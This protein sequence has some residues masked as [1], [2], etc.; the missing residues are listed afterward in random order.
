MEQ[1][2]IH[3]SLIHD[4]EQDDY[5]QVVTVASEEFKYPCDKCD[6]KFR[7]PSS[8]LYHK[9][10][11]H[12]SG[13]RFV[14]SKCSKVFK[15]KQ[16]LQRHQ[17]VHTDD[18]PY[19]CDICQA[20]FKT[21]PNLMN[22]LA[23][24]SGVKKHECRICSQSFA[25]KTSLKLHYRWHAGSKPFECKVTLSHNPIWTYSSDTIVPINTFGLRNAERCSRKTEIYK[26]T[27][28]YI[29]A[30]DP[31]TAITVKRSLRRAPSVVFT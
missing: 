6:R 21:K 30:S 7:N 17:L 12:N 11:E 28:E 8:V 2:N 31:T 16:L 9:D 19:P 5:H 26:S 10:A 13:R 4:I 14:C 25:H 15:L 22:H 29:R 24:H 1:L 27:C 18:R 20:A 23:K 3:V